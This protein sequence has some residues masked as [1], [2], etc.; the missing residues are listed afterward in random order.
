MNS[1]NLSKAPAYNLKVYNIINNDLQDKVFK[2]MDTEEFWNTINDFIHDFNIEHDYTWQAG[3]NGRSGGYLVLYRGGKRTAYYTKEDFNNGTVYIKDGIGWMDYEEAK[4]LN[5]VDRE[6]T[7]S[8]FT[9]PGKEIENNEVPVEVL[10]YFRK[11]AISIVKEA[12]HMA[13]NATVEKEEYQV[14]K[15]RKVVNFR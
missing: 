2:L 14:T 10:K 7:T 11:L 4:K 3:F 13:K 1:W 9:Q 5:L 15:T 12:E 8:I 6:L